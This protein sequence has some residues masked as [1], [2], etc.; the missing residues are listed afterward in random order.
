MARTLNTPVDP[1][2]RQAVQNF[3]YKAT[4]GSAT[5]L[6]PISLVAGDDNDINIY[7]P[8]DFTGW[9]TATGKVAL[10]IPEPGGQPVSGS[11]R[12]RYDED[13]E[14][15]DLPTPTSGKHYIIYAYE[16]GD[17]FTAAGAASAGATGLIFT[18]NGVAPGT[19]TNGSILREVTA[20]LDH[21]ATA[22]EVTTAFNDLGI[23]TG[24]F[25]VTGSGPWTLIYSTVANLTSFTILADNLYPQCNGVPRVVQSGD[26]LNKREQIRISLKQAALALTTSFS[27]LPAG[28]IA[29]TI[30]QAGGA[31]T[32]AIID[33]VYTSFPYDGNFTLTFSTGLSGTLKTQP[34]SYRATADAV[35][36]AIIALTTPVDG[37]V[38]VTAIRNGWRIQ[39]T[40]L[41][42]NTA[43]A[44]PSVDY[45][46]VTFAVG[47]QVQLDLDTTNVE[48]YTSGSAQVPAN[49]EIELTISGEI[50]TPLILPCTL[51][52]EGLDSDTTT[53]TP[54]D[55][56]VTTSQI[57]VL[58]PDWQ[59]TITALT[60]GAAD[61]LD[62]IATVDKAIGYRVDIYIGG[63]VRSYV[64]TAGTEAENSP[65][66]VRPDDYAS[67]TNEKYWLAG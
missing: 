35:Q 27:N 48:A 63:V 21:D 32:N 52:N 14:V 10:L 67:S 18:A 40:G 57:G 66:V 50:Q 13:I 30:K 62:S 45:S 46:G 29:A 8:A 60:G 47:R 28:S 1:E 49:L 5:Q 12:A 9:S 58:F 56:P 26:A 23:L 16:A 39:F 44:A 25:T 65:L 3:A 7:C 43:V 37:D 17:N 38:V 36:S 54:T 6:A 42:A 59:P 22:A 34:I 31:S 24:T 15:A 53:S 33:V 11:W 55:T 51:I 64:L 41:M 20:E 2:I 61:A 19:W 4:G